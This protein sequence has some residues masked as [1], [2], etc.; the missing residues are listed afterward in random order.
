MGDEVLRTFGDPG[1]VTDAEL[2]RLGEGGREH[3]PG[4]IGQRAGLAGSALSIGKRQPLQS[5]LLGDLEVETEQVA[6]I[7]RDAYILMPV[8]MLFLASARQARVG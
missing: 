2:F 3:E 7:G 5:Q 8:E 1:E 4:R 6:M